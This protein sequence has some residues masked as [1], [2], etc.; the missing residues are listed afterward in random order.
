MAQQ[1]VAKFN[2]QLEDHSFVH[3]EQLVNTVVPANLVEQFELAPKLAALAENQRF[4]QKNDK[5]YALIPQ[6]I[7]P[8][9]AISKRLDTIKF[10]D[11]SRTGDVYKLE[12]MLLNMLLNIEEA[13][14]FLDNFVGHEKETIHVMVVF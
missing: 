8:L 7:A 12:S 6:L 1:I 4:V 3:I 5:F 14:Y 11:F 10:T 13:Y 2:V 9:T